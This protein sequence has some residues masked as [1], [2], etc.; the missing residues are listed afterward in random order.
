MLQ[1]GQEQGALHHFADLRVDSNLCWPCTSAC[2]DNHLDLHNLVQQAKVAH[3]WCVRVN[4]SIIF[5]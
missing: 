4:T 5:F 1:C 2:L 3:D